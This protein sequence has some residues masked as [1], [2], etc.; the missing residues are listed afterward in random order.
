[1]IDKI[2]SGIISGIFILVLAWLFKRYK[3]NKDT[4]LIIS[5]LNES[6]ENTNY[7]FRTTHVI[8]SETNLPEV[9]VH[10]LCSKSKRIKR[11]TKI[12]ESWKLKNE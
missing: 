5:C 12:K 8:A 10:N 4:K 1:M 11:N 9:R 3:D 7:R 2:T 6:K